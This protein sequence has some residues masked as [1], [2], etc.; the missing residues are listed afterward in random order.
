MELTPTGAIDG[1]TAVHGVSHGP[2]S[3]GHRSTR[4]RTCAQHNTWSDSA[5]G[6]IFNI[7]AVYDSVRPFRA[8]RNET[9]Y[10]QWRE[11]YGRQF[12]FTLLCEIVRCIDRHFRADSPAQNETDAR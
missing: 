3:R 5:T 8:C 1:A 6:R 10:H 4:D 9:S 11:K 2:N 7:L 12:H